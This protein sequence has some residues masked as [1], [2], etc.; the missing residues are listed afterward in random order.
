[1]LQRGNRGDRVES[2]RY[3]AKLLTVGKTRDGGEMEVRTGQA[4]DR[5]IL[6][7]LLS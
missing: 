5:R 1:M 7:A 4:G 3:A 2:E 6:R